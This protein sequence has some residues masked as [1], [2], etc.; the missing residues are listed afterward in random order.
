VKVLVATAIYP[1]PD[2][3]AFGTFVRTQVESLRR[4]GVD[5]DPFVLEGRNR[6]LMYLRGISL[7]RRRVRQG[8]V[9][10]VHAHY[11]YVGAVARAQRTVPV[12]LTFHGDDLLG[13]I[14]ANGRHTM[15]SRAIVLGGKA[16][17][18][19]IDAIVVQ[20]RTMAALLRWHPRVHVIPHEVDLE[21]FRPSERDE[22]RRRLGLD[23]HRRY[24][25]FASPPDIHVKRFPL[26]QASVELL[27]Q[28]YPSA[29]LLVVFKET[30]D[31][32]ALYMSACDALVFPS[33][34]EGS[35]N[36]VK[37]AMA[38]NLPIVATDVGDVAEV[39]GETEG[40]HLVQPDARVF[41]SRLGEVIERRLRTT[42]RDRVRRFESSRVASRLLEVYSEVVAHA[43]VS[44]QPSRKL[45]PASSPPSGA[46]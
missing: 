22:A 14:G 42:G 6:K 19:S 45:R 44:V 29:E 40:C 12:V 15:F 43:A 2:R 8:D 21:L 17:A 37:Q 25:L 27:R 23:P 28:R 7:L 39:L 18:R 9:D 32:L 31:R 38:C 13:T 26:A 4:I 11:S 33:Y 16:L 3:P 41:A 30:Q 5:A 36:V 46:E 24:V 1:T 10:L 35:P 20:N 34:Q